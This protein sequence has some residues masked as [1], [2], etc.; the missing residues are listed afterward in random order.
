MYPKELAM[1]PMARLAQA[2]SSNRSDSTVLMLRLNIPIIYPSIAYVAHHCVTTP[3]WSN[4]RHSQSIPRHFPIYIVVVLV[5]LHCLIFSLIS[6]AEQAWCS[7]K[8][9]REM[10]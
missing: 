5:R 10:L 9:L 4:F 2:S 7:L 6:E 8:D 3:S 1:S